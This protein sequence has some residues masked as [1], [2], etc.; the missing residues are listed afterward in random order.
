MTLRI[1]GIKFPTLAFRSIDVAGNFIQGK[2]SM[3]MSQPFT[4]Q[5]RQPLSTLKP[6]STPAMLCWAYATEMSV[7]SQRIVRSHVMKQEVCPT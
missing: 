1:I 4:S 5:Q 7:R 6:V 3:F 2:S